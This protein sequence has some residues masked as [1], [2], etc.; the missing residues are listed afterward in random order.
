MGTKDFLKF[1]WLPWF[2]AKTLGYKKSW[3]TLYF[4]LL[5][6]PIFIWRL[7][8]LSQLFHSWNLSPVFSRKLNF[9]VCFN[10]KEDK[11]RTTQPNWDFLTFTQISKWS[12]WSVILTTL[13]LTCSCCNCYSFTFNF[14]LNWISI[15]IWSNSNN[16]Q[17]EM[18]T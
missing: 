17:I 5:P 15:Q 18:M 7:C 3:E 8:N 12:F 16:C 11:V 13:Q 6:I 2:P 14:I 1:W 9:W 4:V 10:L